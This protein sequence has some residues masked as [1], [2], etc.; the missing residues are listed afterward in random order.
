M[1]GQ[2]IGHLTVV[3][4]L[5]AYYDHGE[6]ACR[7]I[8][9][10]GNEC[11]KGSNALKHYRNPPHCGCMTTYYKQ[12]QSERNRKDVS[13]MRF[14]SLVVDHMIYKRGDKTKVA[15]ICDCGNYIE[16][17]LT[18]VTSGDTTS[19]G[20]VQRRRASES[21]TKDFTGIK[22]EYGVEFIRRAQQNSRGVW[23]WL[24]RCPLC[25]CEFMALPAKVLNGHITSCGCSKRSSRERLISGILDSLNVKYAEEYVF[26]DCKNEYPLRFDFY[27]PNYNTVIEYQGEQHYRVVPQWGGHDGLIIRERNDEIKRLYCMN[28]HILL[29][30]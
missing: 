25:G 27:L 1:T 14:G 24:C 6:S 22:S 19:C 2:K 17:Y 18:Y 10:C 9:E 15:C 8:C 28:N 23:M 5:Y 21:N 26:H 13:G 20:C 16:T 7:C 3:E 12:V 30:E 29:L 4:M 11:I